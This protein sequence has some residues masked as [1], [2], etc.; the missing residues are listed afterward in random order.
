M[1]VY[2]C[3]N[4]IRL[5]SYRRLLYCMCVCVCCQRVN[6][7]RRSL[8][9]VRG[10]PLRITLLGNVHLSVAF[11]ILRDGRIGAI[12]TFSLGKLEKCRPNRPLNGYALHTSLSVPYLHTHSYKLFTFLKLVIPHFYLHQHL[13]LVPVLN[14]YSGC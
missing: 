10:R 12:A 13:E 5:L 2:K 3:V 4:A 7:L 8:P 14:W 11:D 6:N 9:L 1:Y